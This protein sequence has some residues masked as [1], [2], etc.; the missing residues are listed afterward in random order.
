[1]IAA[2]DYKRLHEAAGRDLKLLFVAHRQEI[3]KQAM[4]TYRDV[5]QD[6]AFGELYVGA[7]KPEEWKHIFASVQSFRPSASNS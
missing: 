3:L 4:R 5:M 6:G 1:M 7:H 2:L